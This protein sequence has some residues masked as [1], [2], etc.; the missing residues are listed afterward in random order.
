MNKK[1]LILFCILTVVPVGLISWLAVATYQSEKER[2]I[3]YQKDLARERLSSLD[4]QL[5]SY[6]ISLE[7]ELTSLIAGIDDTEADPLRRTTR[8]EPLIR[9][10]FIIEGER[11]L[12]FP[13]KEI[14]ISQKEEDF[15]ARTKEIGLT[16][17]IFMQPEES[18]SSSSETQTANR[19]GTAA[20][21]SGW[22]TY[23]LGEGLNFIFWRRLEREN[24]VIGVE[25]NRMAVVSGIIR[26]LP[27]TEESGSEAAPF[28]VSLA[29][30]DEGPVYHFGGY[31]PEEED[32]PMVSLPLSPPLS[33]WKL[34][35]YTSPASFSLSSSRGLTIF[36]SLG[37]LVLIVIG[38][39]V[40]FYR[41]ST[42]EVREAY[43]RVN[44]V[45][46]VSH[47]L[48]TP[49]TNIRIYSELLEPRLPEAD[50]KGKR[51]LDILVSESHRL[52]RLIGNVLTFAKEQKQG[53][54]LFPIPAV[55]D[56]V[57]R[58]VIEHFRPALIKKGI[59]IDLIL[60]ASEKVLLDRDVLE[61]IINNVVGNVEKYAA[62]GKYLRIETS[63]DTG[64]GETIITVKDR[65]PGIPKHLREKVFQPF[66]RISNQSTDGVAGTGIGL[67]LVRGLAKLHGGTA[68][69]L[70]C[71]GGA[72]IRVVLST[73][74]ADSASEAVDNNKGDIDEKNK[75]ER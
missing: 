45:N 20:A 15:L 61:Q 42:R 6:F 60:D 34:K 3:Q 35:Y 44:F 71:K 48:K 55:P 59:E 11:G 46:Q 69:V 9:Q 33:S 1:L 64:K 24:M 23:Y 12:V 43:K 53:V 27:T 49:L 72:R 32:L 58:S 47:E 29:D 18:P 17:G 54:E 62:Q 70:Q 36:G 30:E 39:A 75:G 74:P 41:E 73:P 67:S 25:C 28:R 21:E 51:Y 16:M 40:Y 50:A 66:Y 13:S 57:V 4:L 63:Q 38:L 19:P 22:Y 31:L 5:Q 8:R 14:P 2:E 52:S 26:T 7:K 65:G 68:K 10:L 37:A 56:D